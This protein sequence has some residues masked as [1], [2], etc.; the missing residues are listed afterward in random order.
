MPATR[1]LDDIY[2]GDAYDHRV[3][4]QDGDGTALD[5]TGTW[6]AQIKKR[7]TDTAV[8]VE[9]D[10]DDSDAATG[11]IWLRLTEEQT[12]ALDEGEAVWDLEE[13]GAALT[14]LRGDVTITRDVTR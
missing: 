5:M 8:L 2:T 13:T 4:F 10:V 12:A 3:T 7:A 9:F 6:R 14:Y 11:I 1:N